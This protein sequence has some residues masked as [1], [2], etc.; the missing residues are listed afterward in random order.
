MASSDVYTG[1]EG[2]SSGNCQDRLSAVVLSK[3]QFKD[4]ILERNLESSEFASVKTEHEGEHLQVK[5]EHIDGITVK[6]EPEDVMY[7]AKREVIVSTSSSSGLQYDHSKEKLDKSTEET[8]VE[9]IESEH[10]S[11]HLKDETE[12][13]QNNY[14]DDDNVINENQFPCD[15]CGK[16]FT[17]KKYLTAHKRLHNGNLSFSCEICQKSFNHKGH[18]HRHMHVHTGEGFSCEVCGKSFTQRGGLIIHMRLHTGDLFF[19]DMCDKS[20]THKGNLNIHRRIHSD[21]HPFSCEICGKFFSCKSRLTGHMYLHSEKSFSCDVCGRM[22]SQKG[23][24]QKH[25][26]RHADDVIFPCEIW[27]K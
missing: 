15:E 20:F 1:I 23:N 14:E 17:K 25:R 10:Q 18:L 4:I 24:L 27:E 19:C 7:E 11:L 13:E 12:S 21:Q 5:M 8:E 9:V 3:T 2:N 16:T 22:F 26:R 6:M